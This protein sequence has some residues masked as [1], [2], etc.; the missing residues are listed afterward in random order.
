[1]VFL[2]A[3]AS[4]ERIV[5]EGSKGLIEY[6]DGDEGEHVYSSYYTNFTLS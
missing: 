2:I 3:T 4:T 6:A 5:L 1:M